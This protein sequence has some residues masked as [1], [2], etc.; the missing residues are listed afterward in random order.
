MDYVGWENLTKAD[1]SGMKS[2]MIVKH[3][4]P[5]NLGLGNRGLFRAACN[6]Y[7]VMV[8]SV[9]GVLQEPPSNACLKCLASLGVA[10]ANPA[11]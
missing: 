6:T 5:V 9:S 8:S 3:D 2:H 10:E 11:S 4:K 7:G 1:G